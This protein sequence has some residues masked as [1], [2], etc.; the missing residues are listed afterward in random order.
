[1]SSVAAFVPEGV[2]RR[3]QPASTV[4]M[5]EFL[6]FELEVKCSLLGLIVLAS[7]HFPLFSFH[8]ARPIM[9]GS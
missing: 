6:S 2:H 8:L 9:V 3:E 7:C 4:S 5:A 1:M